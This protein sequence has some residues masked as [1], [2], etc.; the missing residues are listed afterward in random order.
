MGR[1]LVAQAGPGTD[2]I[3]LGCRSGGPA[4]P[5]DAV[6]QARRRAIL[7]GQGEPLDEHAGAGLDHPLG[8]QVILIGGEFEE[9]QPQAPRLWGDREANAAFAHVTGLSV[10]HVMVRTLGRGLPQRSIAVGRVLP[11]G[12]V[13]VR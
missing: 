9:R 10:T 5:V 6:L 1:G 11:P 8:R 4:W 13:Q 12:R 7:S 3:N 2:C